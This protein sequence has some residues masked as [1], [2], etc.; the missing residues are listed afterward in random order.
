MSEWKNTDMHAGLTQRVGISKSKKGEVDARQ[1]KQHRKRAETG[2]RS[3]CLG[4][5]S[6][7]PREGRGRSRSKRVRSKILSHRKTWEPD[8]GDR[9]SQT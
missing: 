8:P 1:R 5:F 7:S 9:A 3:V 6:L 4:N 2:N